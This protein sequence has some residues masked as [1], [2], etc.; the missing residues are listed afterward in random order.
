MM[1]M[2]YVVKGST[3]KR[4]LRTLI[5]D[6]FIKKIDIYVNDELY[7]SEKLISSIIYSP[8]SSFELC[9]SSPACST[10]THNSIS[11]AR[12]AAARPTLMNVLM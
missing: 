6:N 8:L 4:H 1:V 2:V 10:K 3:Q 11:K 12:K 7:R 5:T 9:Y